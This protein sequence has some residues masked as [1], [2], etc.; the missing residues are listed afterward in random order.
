[1][2][3]LTIATSLIALAFAGAAAAQAPRRDLYVGVNLVDPQR[4]TIT[5]DSYILVENGRIAATGRGRPAAARGAT[6][7]DF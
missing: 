7:H 4:E 2:R 5:P 3:R 6:L 1:M